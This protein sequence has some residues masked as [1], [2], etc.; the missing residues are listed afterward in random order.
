MKKHFYYTISLLSVSFILFSCSKE[1]D[2]D[3]QYSEPL[4]VIEGWIEQDGSA[5]ILL[6][7]SIPYFGKVESDSELMN[8]SVRTAKVILAGNGDFE[9]LTLKRNEQYFPPYIY[10]SNKIL[11]EINGSYTLTVISS[12]D[13]IFSHTTIPEPVQL[14]SAWFQ[15]EDGNDTAGRVWIQFTDR[16]ES[17]DYY[18]VFTQR[19]G[20]DK[21]FVPSYISTIPDKVFNGGTM[22]VGLLRGAGSLIQVGES[23]YF[24][25]GDTILVKFC[26]LDKEHFDFWDSV[27]SEIIT[28]ANPFAASNA[29]VKS[30]VT[31]PGFGIWGGYGSNYYTVI[32]K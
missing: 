6:T 25:K 22:K 26:T 5:K 9:I 30:N 7:R 3:F 31:N 29:R 13:T 12:G 18:R 23:R 21:R 17:I 15:Y 24:E 8:L 27:Q 28:S 1:L 11:G 16:A 10:T 19:I 20:K 32:A 2:L 4:L 14:D